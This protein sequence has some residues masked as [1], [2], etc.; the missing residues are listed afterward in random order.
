MGDETA[1]TDIVLLIGDLVIQNGRT[2]RPQKGCAGQIKKSNSNRNMTI[3]SPQAKVVGRPH[4]GD[5]C[6]LRSSG[7][8]ALDLHLSGGH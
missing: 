5:N 4:G 8:G 3:H 2:T 1:H 7:P 6:V